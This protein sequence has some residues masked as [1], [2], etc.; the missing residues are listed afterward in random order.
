MSLLARGNC[1]GNE[2]R[3]ALIS[4]NLSHDI[5]HSIYDSEGLIS[6]G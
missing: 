4:I 6:E 2:A 1:S 5:R 3:S